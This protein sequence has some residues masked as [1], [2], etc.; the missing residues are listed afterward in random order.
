MIG[1]IIAYGDTREQALL[2][3]RTALGETVIEGIST[4]I[5]LHREL[6]VDAKFV[7]GGT[8]IHYLEDWLAKRAR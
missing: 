1:K 5:A 3:M 4:N 8:N 2:R 7:Q 6:V